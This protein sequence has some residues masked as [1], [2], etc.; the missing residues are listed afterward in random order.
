MNDTGGTTD[1][2]GPPG[3]AGQDRVVAWCVV[4]FDGRR[5]GPD[6]RAE[7]LARL[8]FR[9]FAYDWRA[10]HLPSLPAELA[11]LARAGIALHAVWFPPRLDADARYLLDVL[12]DAGLAP[13]LWTTTMFDGPEHHTPATHA[14]LVA[15]HVRTLA[16]LVEA[17]ETLGAR[18]GLYNHLGWFGEPEHQLEI[19]DALGS[20]LVGI[21]YNQHHGH[22]HVDRFAELLDAVLP[23]L[24]CVTLNGTTRDGDR[25]GRKILPLGHGEL[26]RSLF[27][28]LDA[29]GYRGPLALLGHTDDDAEQRLAENLDGLRWLLDGATAADPWRAP[30]PR[31]SRWRAEG[32]L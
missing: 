5:R 9:R 21:V 28:A 29:S 24:L 22:A 3:R 2:L 31:V 30:E 19:L 23:H 1:P 4:P 10:E 27:A 8:G 12:A 6:E 18:V 17:A 20:P 7:M 32:L 13:E 25:T 11:A 16:P 15:E 14:R 26:D